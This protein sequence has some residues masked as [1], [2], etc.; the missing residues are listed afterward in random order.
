MSFSVT[1]DDAAVQQKVQAFVTS[2]NSLMTTISDLRSYNATTK[3]AGPL[4]GDSMLRGIESQVRKVIS[5]NVVGGTSKYVNLASLGISTQIN[6]TL[7]LDSTKF[8]AALKADAS[9][10]GQVFGSTN[11]I[12][13]RIDTLMT[14]HLATTGDLAA[15]DA[16]ITA[17]RKDLDKQ[18]TALDARMVVIEARYTKQ[19]S[20]LDSLLTQMQ[21][22]STYLAQQLSKSVG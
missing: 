18:K 13:K 21:S 12:A 5:D 4:L 20:A 1:N 11:G 3:V 22:T 19:F 16:S 15:R 8:A 14:L 9:S 7:A 6:G 10:V 2:Y 17:R